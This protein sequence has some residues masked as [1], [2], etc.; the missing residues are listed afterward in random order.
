MKRF[1]AVAGNIGAGK[2]SLT[3]LLSE[4]LGWEPFYEVADENP[5]L[6]EVYQDMARWCFHSEIFFLA[7]KLHHYCLLL[8]TPSSVIQDRTIYEDAEVFVENFYREGLMSERDYRTYRQLYE[9]V[10]SILPPPDLVIYLQASIPTLEKRI[11]MRGRDYEKKIPRE[12]LE[13]LNNLYEEWI[14]RYNL[15]P[16]LK[17]PADRL[18]FVHSSRHLDL[19]VEKILEKLQSKEVV[20]F[21]D[22][23]G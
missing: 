3:R 11:A 17:V 13:K 20:N 2:S 18:D 9:A 16:V 19:I 6:L 8:K 1:I 4:R 7:R 23:E 15:S 21:D 14:E 22:L 10:I 12:Y 5:Y